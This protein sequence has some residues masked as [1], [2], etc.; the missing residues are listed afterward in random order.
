MVDIYPFQLFRHLRLVGETGGAGALLSVQ[1]PSLL[2]SEP[3]RG[4]GQAE[5]ETEESGGCQQAAP[6]RPGPPASL[7][8]LGYPCYRVNFV[9]CAFTTFSMWR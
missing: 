7:L 2:E 1:P 3:E 5:T 4:G 9:V 8:G 6:A